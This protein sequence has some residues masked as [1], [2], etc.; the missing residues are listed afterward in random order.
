M[1]LAGCATYIG[2]DEIAVEKTTI[3]PQIAAL[4]GIAKYQKSNI[5]LK[6]GESRATL[7]LAEILRLYRKQQPS[8]VATQ[9]PPMQSSINEIN[10][11][12]QLLENAMQIKARFNIAILSKEQWI[13][14]PLFVK[15][16]DMHIYNLP[17]LKQGYLVQDKDKISYITKAQGKVEFELSMLKQAQTDENTRKLQVKFSQAIKTVMALRYDENLF[18]LE[19][20]Q[21]LVNADGSIIYPENGMF[22][23]QWQ[24]TSHSSTQR[25]VAVKPP[26]EPMIKQAN[27]SSIATLEGELITRVLYDLHFEGTEQLSFDI[28]T[29]FTLNKVYLNGSAIPFRINA[30]KVTI[31]VLPSRAGDRQGSLELTFH[32]QQGKFHLSGALEFNAPQTSWP[33]REMFMRVYLP[34]VFNY[35]YEGGSMSIL[36]QSKVV[37]YTYD[38]PTPGKA[39]SFHQLLITSSAPAVKINYTIDLEGKYF[40]GN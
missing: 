23:V 2:A 12:A 34:S 1:L 21:N 18:K 13:S 20:K 10:I 25:K 27:V 6:G 33:I 14:I 39:F 11:E 8:E 16:S 40:N 15:D 7:P 4:E 31:E 38:L 5:T 24:Q 17:V 37:K 29:G 22:D 30:G 3:N 32:R 19:S 28:P 35:S 36:N 26:L 9:P